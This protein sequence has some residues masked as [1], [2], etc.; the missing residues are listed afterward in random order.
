[1]EWTLL[2]FARLSGV[3]EGAN[4]LMKSADVGHWRKRDEMVCND[5]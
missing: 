4:G 3:G 5:Q 1:M 2:D